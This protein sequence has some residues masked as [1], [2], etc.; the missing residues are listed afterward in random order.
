[1]FH[2]G[3]PSLSF[4]SIAGLSTG[5]YAANTN[6]TNGGGTEIFWFR[7]RHSLTMGG[8]VRRHAFDMFSQQNA[9]GS[10]GFT[11]AASG[12]DV[13]DFMLKQATSSEFLRMV[14]AIAY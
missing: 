12:S 13:A 7:G 1:M 10:F 4:T 14:P 11:G 8:G 9:R 6:L 5:Q 3:P 2:W